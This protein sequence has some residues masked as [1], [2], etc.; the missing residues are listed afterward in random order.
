MNF[1]RLDRRISLQSQAVSVSGNGERT[2]GAWTSYATNVPAEERQ[3]SAR[4]IMAS[5]TE[6]AQITM[7]FIIRY[8]EDVTTR[9]RAV[10]NGDIYD[11]EAVR[12]IGRR[13]GLELQCTRHRG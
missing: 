8:R 4:E 11:I 10:Y 6:Q 3:Q 9:H 2:A 13:E 12:E 5:G 1:G 7:A